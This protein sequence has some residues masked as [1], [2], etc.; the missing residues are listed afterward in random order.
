MMLGFGNAAAITARRLRAQEIS[1]PVHVNRAGERL[2]RARDGL[3]VDR[4]PIVRGDA[5][6]DGPT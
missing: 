5:G 3:A 2:L 6:F 1:S 4:G